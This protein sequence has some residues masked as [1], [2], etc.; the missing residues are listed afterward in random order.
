MV[1]GSLVLLIN[2]IG[3][4]SWEGLDDTGRECLAGTG[5]R[6]MQILLYYHYYT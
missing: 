5:V 4:R 3:L 6:Q 2:N 1:T